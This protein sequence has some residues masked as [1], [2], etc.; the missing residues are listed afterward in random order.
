M[1]GGPTLVVGHSYGGSIVTEAGVHP[2]VVGLVYVDAHAPDVGEDQGSL[3]RRH[4]ACS[5]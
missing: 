2:S 5:P 3:G 1:L 4:P